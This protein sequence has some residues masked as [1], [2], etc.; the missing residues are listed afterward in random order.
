METKAIIKGMAAGAVVGTAC[1]MISRAPDHKKK[2]LKRS[3]GK[4]VKAFVTAADCFSSM[5]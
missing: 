1:Y 4:A 2:K 3:T 5:I